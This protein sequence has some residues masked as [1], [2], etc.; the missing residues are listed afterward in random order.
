[1]MN[2][3]T[4]KNKNSS[5]ESLKSVSEYLYNLSANIRPHAPLN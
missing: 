4:K 2:K 3:K 5:A 1:M